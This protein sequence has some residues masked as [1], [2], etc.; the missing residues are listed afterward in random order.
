[1]NKELDY[2]YIA[3]LLDGEGTISISNQFYLRACIRNTDLKVL[4]W[5]QSFMGGAIYPDNRRV[6][7]C[8]SLEYS[9]RTVEKFLSRLCPYLRIKKTQAEFALSLNLHRHQKLTLDERERRFEAYLKMRE[10]NL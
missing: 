10:L 9:S 4:E 2:A 7:P 1:M 3:G 5:I 6:K 8:Y